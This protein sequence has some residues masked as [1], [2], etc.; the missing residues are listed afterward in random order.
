MHSL[1]PL[2]MRQ[3]R[4]IMYSL[5]PPSGSQYKLQLIYLCKL[6]SE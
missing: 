2:W 5:L 3:H 6:T 4:V 1:A